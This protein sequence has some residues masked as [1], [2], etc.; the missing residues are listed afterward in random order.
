MRPDRYERLKEIVLRIAELPEAQRSAAVREACGDDVELRAE[1]ESLLAQPLPE[2]ETR[3]PSQPR[4]ETAPAQSQGSPDAGL[5]AL[6]VM[7]HEIAAARDPR[8]DSA[9]GELLRGA[10]DEVLRRAGEVDPQ[11]SPF[12][13]E[14]VRKL[15]ARNEESPSLSL[16]E[17]AKVLAEGE[18]SEWWGARAQA[19][20]L[21][22]ARAARRLAVDR[23]TRLYG[24]DEEMAT[25]ERIYERVQ[26]GNGQV[27]L[28]EGETGIGKTRLVDAF[29]E[30]LRAAGEDPEF[31]FGGYAGIPATA[32]SPP[33]ADAWRI[34]YGERIGLTRLEERLEN[35]LG[36]A[37]TLIPAFAAFLRGDPPGGLLTKDSLQTAIVQ[38]TCAL[39]AERPTIVLIED[40][41]AAPDQGRALFAA[42]ALA[43]PERRILLIGTAVQHQPEEWRGGIE[44]MEQTSIMI[45]GRLGTTDLAALLEEAFRSEDLARQLL[46]PI[47][48]KSDGVPLFVFEILRALREG[49][50]L[51]AQ[52]DGSWSRT[53]E[54][55]RIETPSSML[56]L[57]EARTSRL[58]EEDRRLL[59]IASCFGFEF[60]PLQLAEASGISALSVLRR[61]S[62]I[63]RDHGLIRSAGSHFAFDLHEVREVL[64]GSLPE[65]VRRRHRAA[66]ERAQAARRPP[67]SLT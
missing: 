18:E 23:E 14:V 53:R 29:V 40:L 30:R 66:I 63:E 17:M 54:I 50:L 49:G 26:G 60:D 55:S 61:L 2:E 4:G 27:L 43:V 22:A 20:G 1:V 52:P 3:P 15:V 5:Q 57:I 6:C 47:A 56:R 19:L 13:D 48:L 10:L 25:L 44:R 42:L 9:M 62:R 41:H 39:A 45:L 32:A 21:A 16:S 34:A 46:D 35:Y 11:L 24:R 12:L 51:T 58:C 36:A 8:S 7:L 33:E 67:A 28:I 64:Y 38:V 59:E 65:R 37:T 31:L